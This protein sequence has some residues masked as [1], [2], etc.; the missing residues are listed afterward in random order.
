[1]NIAM[2]PSP[3]GSAERRGGLPLLP[4]SFRRPG[5]GAE[6]GAVVARTEALEREREALGRAIEDRA[7][8]VGRALREDVARGLAARGVEEDAE[9]LAQVEW[10]ARFGTYAVGRYLAEGLFATEEEL[11]RVARAGAYGLRSDVRV[12]DLAKRWLLWRDLTEAAVA[13]E[14]AR[15]GTAAPVVAEAV[16]MVR[17]SCDASLVRMIG[18]FDERRSAL[19]RALQAERAKLAHQ[20]R[21]DALT[22]VVNR[23]ALLE[24]LDERLRRLAAWPSTSE[25]TPVVEGCDGQVGL[26]LLYVDIDHFKAVN[27]TYGHVV[28]DQ[29]LVRVAERL[30]AAVRPGDL[31]ARLGGDEFVVCVDPCTTVLDAARLADRLGSLLREPLDLAGRRLAVTASIGVAVAGPGSSVEAVLSAAD[32]AMY[33]AKQA[34]RARYALAGIPGPA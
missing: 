15:L 27:D 17:L 12:A 10:V 26:S 19:E 34:G 2:S 9:L 28:G 8:D 33:R 7:E 32:R 13:E 25:G 4:T 3:S 6:G 18:F 31:V 5:G 24:R 22:G 1:M 14:A 21:H 11:E 23:G 16:T 20:A 30:R 29:L